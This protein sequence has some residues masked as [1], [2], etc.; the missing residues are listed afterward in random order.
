MYSDTIIELVSDHFKCDTDGIAPEVRRAIAQ[1]MA[2][3]V[4]AER[5]GFPK[6][7]E[8]SP[9]TRSALDR[10]NEDGIAVTP[11]FLDAA[12]VGKIND[13]FEHK[14]M[15]QA[16]VPMYAADKPPV[17]L[18]QARLSDLSIF[19][20]SPRDALCCPELLA[21]ML[22][23]AILS[24]AQSYLGCA[25]TLY[26]VNA[27]RTLPKGVAVVNVNT[28]HRDHDGFRFVAFFIYLTDV[29]ADSG[30]FN[31]VPGSHRGEA[32]GTNK[33]E[34][35]GKKGT[36]IIVDPWGLHYGRPPVAGERFVCW[37]R[38][39]IGLPGGYFQDK[40]YLFK[41]SAEELA[42]DRNDEELQYVLR[43]FLSPFGS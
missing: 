41:A 23:P 16:H 5:P 34:V 15:F 2:G 30:P 6:S 35:I 12:S 36:L 1:G 28:P 39:G 43:G 21:V 14:R 3:I 7:A 26:S 9:R 10:L 17:S 19:S 31:Y 22:D 4:A 32:P 18:E 42:F 25:P 24:I 20:Y 29:P 27:F 8:A 13:Y 37:W 33:V 11:D 38:F 40:N